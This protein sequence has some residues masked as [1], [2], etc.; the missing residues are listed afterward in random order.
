M[1]LKN[2][3]RTMTAIVVILTVSFNAQ[4][5]SGGAPKTATEFFQ[6]G[7]AYFEDGEYAKAIADFSQSLKLEPKGECTA[8]SYLYRG[9][10]YSMQKDYAQAIADLNQADKLA[11]NDAG[12]LAWRGNAYFLKYEQRNPKDDGNDLKRRALADLN[13]SIQVQPDYA[14]AYGK[15]GYYYSD[16]ISTKDR[17]MADYNMAIQLDPND[18]GVYKDR[19]SLYLWNFNDPNRAI[20]DYNQAIKLNPN[21]AS[22]YYCRGTAY[23]KIAEFGNRNYTQAIA[24]YTQAIKLDPK[25]HVKY[26]E[27]GEAYYQMGNYRNAIPDLEQALK[28]WTGHKGSYHGEVQWYLEDARKKR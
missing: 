11:P 3:F 16:D 22:Y 15:R 13:A 1:K 19:G 28:L 20:A 21:D 12:V 2:I 27:R 23:A 26:A 25:D 9:I 10:G 8:V 5:Q 4:A 14:W 6:R 18:P 7:Y 24:D 17:A